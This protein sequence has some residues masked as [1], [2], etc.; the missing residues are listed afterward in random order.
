MKYGRYLL[1]NLFSGH[2][3][4]P[5]GTLRNRPRTYPLRFEDL[6]ELVQR[7][8]ILS[9]QDVGDAFDLFREV[10]LLLT[11]AKE[12]IGAFSQWFTY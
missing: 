4:F 3:C 1:F 2:R 10:D 12:E 9:A 8:G 6:R 7:D 11:P 5:G